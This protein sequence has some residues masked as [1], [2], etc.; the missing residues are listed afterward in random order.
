MDL[1][2]LKFKALDTEKN[3]EVRNENNRC[4]LALYFVTEAQ[5]FVQ[6]TLAYDEIV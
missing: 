4:L 2:C 6:Q 5:P 1:T 3:Y